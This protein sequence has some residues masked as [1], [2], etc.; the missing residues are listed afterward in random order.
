MTKTMTRVQ[1]INAAL[2]ALAALAVAGM[3]SYSLATRIRHKAAPSL[4]SDD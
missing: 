3:G 2:A 1:T 4:R